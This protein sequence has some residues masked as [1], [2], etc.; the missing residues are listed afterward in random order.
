[1]PGEPPYVA[2]VEGFLA[3]RGD[4]LLRA[5]I[6]LAGSRDAGEDLLQDLMQV[7]I[8]IS[9]GRL[10]SAMLM[11]RLRSNSRKNR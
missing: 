10:S 1:M 11:R 2:E 3:E 6:V 5:A 8:S 7:A 4:H 9:E